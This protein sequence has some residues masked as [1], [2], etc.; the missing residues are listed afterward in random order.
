MK[1][2]VYWF[3]GNILKHNNMVIFIYQYEKI[4][5]SIISCDTVNYSYLLWGLKNILVLVFF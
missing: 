4:P 5:W 2:H 3:I 1:K